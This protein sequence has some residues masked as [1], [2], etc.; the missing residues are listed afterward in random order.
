MSLQF[1]PK[2]RFSEEQVE[3]MI[4]DLKDLLGRL[5]EK[6][7]FDFS[8]EKGIKLLDSDNTM[9]EFRRTELTEVKR[10]ISLVKSS[11]NLLTYLTRNPTRLTSIQEVIRKDRIMGSINIQKTNLINVNTEQKSKKV[12]CNEI[13]KTNVTPENLILGQILFSILIYCNRYISTSGILKSG[14]HLDIPTLDGLASIRNYIINLLATNTIKS[15]LLQA[16]EHIN[17]F[18]S[19]FKMMTDRIYLGKVP[20]YFIGIYNMLHQWKY[21]V[22]VSSRNYDLIENTL[23]YYFFGLKNHDQLYECWVFYKILDLL[24]NIFDLRLSETSHSKGSATFK[25]YNNSIRVT[26]QR[27]YETGWTDNLEPVY[28][29]PDM[30]IEFHNNI[31]L[32]MDAKNSIIPP[33]NRYPYRRQMDSYISSAGLNKTKFAILLFSSGKEDDWKEI[34]RKETNTGREHKIIW[35]CLSPTTFSNIKQSNERAIEKIIQLVMICDKQS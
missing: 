25:S 14:A 3:L 15:I 19:L 18:D 28:D 23:R 35:I 7:V 21:F 26:Y 27:I 6:H 17:N 33:G 31:T 20:N 22:W 30:V 9:I 13:H 16:I 10:F 2:V 5:R 12:V 32:I 11:A 24:T 1:E 29:R 8:K 4:T 34:S